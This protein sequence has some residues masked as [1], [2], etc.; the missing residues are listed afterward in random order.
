[1][2]MLVT[3]TLSTSSKDAQKK[4]SVE[5]LNTEEYLHHNEYRCIVM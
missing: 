3:E 4:Q 2:C 5:A 1:M